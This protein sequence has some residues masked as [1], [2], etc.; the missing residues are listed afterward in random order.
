MRVKRGKMVHFLSLGA[1]EP[2]CGGAGTETSAMSVSGV[3]VCA[4]CARR[5]VAQLE[6]RSAP[7]RR[8]QRPGRAVAREPQQN[9]LRRR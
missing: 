2:L 9:V 6:P 3:S 4:E 5:M 1:D 7:A 8:A